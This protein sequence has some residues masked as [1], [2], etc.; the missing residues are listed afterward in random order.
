MP[1][2]STQNW[3]KLPMTAS[4][5]NSF[6][7]Y[8]KVV[9]GL[10]LEQ[11]LLRN[12]ALVYDFFFGD[13]LLGIL[14]KSF[15]GRESNSKGIWHQISDQTESP[16]VNDIESFLCSLP[17]G[18]SSD[19]CQLVVLAIRKIH[20]DN[21]A[22][23]FEYLFGPSAPND[24]S[25]SGI[26][27]PDSSVHS[28]YS[29]YK[30]S[31]EARGPELDPKLTEPA[32]LDQLRYKQSSASGSNNWIPIALIGLL[33][34]AF[35][36]L[37]ATTVENRTTSQSA[38]Q[39]SSYDSTALDAANQL[40]SLESS[41]ASARLV[42]ESQPILDK[43]SSL[44]IVN[45]AALEGRRQALVSSLRQRISALNVTGKDKYGEDA[46]CS[47]GWQWF[48]E[49]GDD[50][51]RIFIVISDKCKEPALRYSILAPSEDK[52]LSSDSINLSGHTTGEVKVP[53]PG[54]ES[55][56]RIDQVSCY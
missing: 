23:E 44:N 47:Y 46:S 36:G 30:K 19:I 12:E 51:W 11:F 13:E 9:D 29:S 55:R 53:Y 16:S 35:L 33:G 27:N 3:T 7:D 22:R 21:I 56:L 50:H 18:I 43:A 38:G 34:V 14:R 32:Y 49:H 10:T 54:F 48:D 41:A 8:K 52:V 45:D 24:A 5:N 28:S 40:S 26:P 25:A 1:G 2:R 20:G 6:L 31:R 39:T 42:C 37:V 15:F 4:Q 17:V